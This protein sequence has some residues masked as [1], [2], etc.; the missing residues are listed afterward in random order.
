[1]LSVLKVVLAEDSAHRHSNHPATQQVVLVVLTLVSLLAE[2]VGVMVHH[3]HHTN[4]QAFHLVVVE[5]M[6]SLLPIQIKMVVLIEVNSAT[7]SVSIC[8]N[9]VYSLLLTIIK[10]F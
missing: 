9:N 4:H 6:L 7:L 8:F 2:P 1:V 10:S 3:H 5:L